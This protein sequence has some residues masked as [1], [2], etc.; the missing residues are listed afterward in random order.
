MEE[1]SPLKNLMDEEEEANDGLVMAV[2]V[3]LYVIKTKGIV[4]QGFGLETL[5]L[6]I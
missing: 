3:P 5:S 1:R 6:S 2:I 4:F